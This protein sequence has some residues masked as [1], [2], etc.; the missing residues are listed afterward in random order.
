VRHDS[1]LL[2]DLDKL[3]GNLELVKNKTSANIMFMV[4]A[5]AYGHG[6]DSISLAAHQWGVASFGVAS[7][8]EGISLRKNLS[9]NFKGEIY[10]FSE[11]NLEQTN[12]RELYLEYRIIPVISNLKSLENLISSDQFNH[13]PLCLKFDTGMNR[14]GMEQEDLEKVIS[15]LKK[16]NRKSIDHLMTHFATSYYLEKTGSRTQKQYNVFKTIKKELRQANIEIEK[17]SVANSGAIE[18]GTGIEESH[19]RPG[20]MLYGPQSTLSQDRVWNGEVISRLESQIL[21]KTK[22]KKGTPIGYGANPCPASGTLLVLPIGYGDGIM[23]YY[24]GAEVRVGKYFGKIVGRVN[25]DLTYVLIPDIDPNEILDQ[26]FC[27]F[28]GHEAAEIEQ[29]AYKMKTIP[30]QLFCAISSRIPRV[31]LN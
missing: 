17:T 28:W 24:S 16:Y 12:L 22:I 19:I 30:Y 10:I 21:T 3:R 20:I 6:A 26:S 7:L 5:N 1:K 11:L 31:Y 18:Q 15:L 29:L 14:L 27:S 23:T 9:I 2:I 4:K 13:V 25:M 8:L